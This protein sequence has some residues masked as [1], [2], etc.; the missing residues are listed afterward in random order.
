MMRRI[1]PVSIA[2]E[3]GWV[4]GASDHEAARDVILGS[5]RTVIIVNDHAF[6]C[7]GQSRIAIESALTLKRAGINVVY[8]AGSGPADSRLEKAG[9]EVVVLGLHDLISDPHPLRAACQGLWNRQAA[10]GLA[11][12]LADHDPLSTVVHVHGWC[13]TLSP[14]IGPVVTRGP[15]AHVYTLHEYFLACPNGGFYDY[16]A[17]RICTRRALGVGCLTTQC[18]ARNG[19]HKA[20]RVARQATLWSPGRMPRDLREV[21][22]LTSAQLGILGSYLPTHA[23]WHHLPNPVPKFCEERIKAEDNREFLF[24][25]RLS[26]EK[27]AEVAAEAARLAGVPIAFAGEGERADA[28]QQANPDAAMLGWLSPGELQE[29]MK[30]AR[31]VV[32]PSLWYETFGLVVGEALRFGLP[33]LVGDS[34]VAAEM[35]RDGIDGY[36]VTSQDA[37][38]WAAR[39]QKLQSDDLVRCLSK[40][41]FERGTTL[42][43]QE[44][45]TEKLI[46]IYDKVLQRKRTPL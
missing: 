2:L 26:P 18:D 16:N 21:I 9:V 42:M 36:H 10:K 1:D 11:S 41:A 43:N 29:R 14:S 46:S 32:F 31:C 20:W 6:I 37:G 35:V 15:F 38:T 4:P 25:G 12:V 23:R 24:V 34:T 22:Y 45:Y 17:G 40:N 7:G 27:G 19:W 3:A 5:V 39:M 30:M 44:E 13:K 28:V 8:F 33:V